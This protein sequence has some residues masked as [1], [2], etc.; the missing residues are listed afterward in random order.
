[1]PSLAFAQSA[2]GNQTDGSEMT[3]G[4]STDPFAAYLLKADNPC[5]SRRYLELSRELP[6]EMSDRKLAGFKQMNN[7]C[8]HFLN[9]IEKSKS[10][11]ETSHSHQKRHNL[12][13]YHMIGGG[14]TVTIIAIVI[15]FD[16][17]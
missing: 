5:N 1:M 8:Q 4:Y 10:A 7:D 15:F 3:A 6:E 16:R 9:L 13:P 17:H 12:K 11:R 14:V 2:A